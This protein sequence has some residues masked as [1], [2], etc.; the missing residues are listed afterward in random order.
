MDDDSAASSTFERGCLVSVLLV[1]AVIAVA[2]SAPDPAH[3]AFRRPHFNPPAP[4]HIPPRYAPPPAPGTPRPRPNRGPIR[5]RLYSAHRVPAGHLVVLKDSSICHRPSCDLLLGQ[6]AKD[7]VYLD[8]VT[9][10][11]HEPC[12]SCRPRR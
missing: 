9:A 1:G 7:V 5:E 3:E 11:D 4:G 8:P 10:R 6:P 12:P 2:A